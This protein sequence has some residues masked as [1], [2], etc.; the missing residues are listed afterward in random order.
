MSYFV[1]GGT[2][3]GYSTDSSVSNNGYLGE[4]LA[5][6]AAQSYYDNYSYILSIKAPT[7]SK[8][9]SEKE[10]W[11]RFALVGDYPLQ[12]ELLSDSSSFELVLTLNYDR[13]YHSQA[14]G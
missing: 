13:K 3:L 8:H 4:A 12:D 6:F 9:T 2:S 10:L 11:D 7:V 5:F 14:R 1:S